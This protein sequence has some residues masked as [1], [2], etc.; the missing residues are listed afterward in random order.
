MTDLLDTNILIYAT[1]H[2]DEHKHKIARQLI[3]DCIT[4]KKH[5]CVSLQNIS[6]FFV[7]AT[8]KIKQPLL[9]HDAMK[10]CQHLLEF[11]GL[12]KIAAKPKTLL[13]AMHL[14]TETKV[15]YWD[16]LI[17]ATMFDHAI[18]TIITENTKDFNKIPRIKA[19]NPFR[20]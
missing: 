20:K 8:A 10:I 9:P 6:E 1:T 14:N 5:F 17:A 13:N 16:C 18:F 19:I 7:V 15:S 2:D 3:E 12:K 11:N 4:E